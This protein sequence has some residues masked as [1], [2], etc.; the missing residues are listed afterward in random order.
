MVGEAGSFGVFSLALPSLVLL[1]VFVIAVYLER[2]Q[3]ISVRVTI[4]L[5]ERSDTQPPQIVDIPRTA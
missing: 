3:K 2:V 5:S 4:C 1:L